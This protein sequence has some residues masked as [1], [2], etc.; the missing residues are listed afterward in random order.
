MQEDEGQTQDFLMLPKDI[1]NCSW[2]EVLA[3]C[4]TE[5]ARK[6]GSKPG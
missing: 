3:I 5:V 6:T 4:P 2:K 1:M